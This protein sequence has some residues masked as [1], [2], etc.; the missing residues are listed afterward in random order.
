MAFFCLYVAA[1]D[2]QVGSVEVKNLMMTVAAQPPPP[3]LHRL[4]QTRSFL[5]CTAFHAG[6]AAKYR[7]LAGRA[8]ITS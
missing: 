8:L 6:V 3:P 5:P 4:H 2:P 7:D 1:K